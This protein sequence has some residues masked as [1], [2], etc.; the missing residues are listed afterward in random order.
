MPAYNDIP[1]SRSRFET[2]HAIAE[3]GHGLF[4]THFIRPPKEK[5]STATVIHADIRDF[6]SKITRKTE[7]RGP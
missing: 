2:A 6:E 3:R 7:N 1:S 4:G 5:N